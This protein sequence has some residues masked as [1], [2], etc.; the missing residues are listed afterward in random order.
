MINSVRYSLPQFFLKGYV[1]SVKLQMAVKH[2]TQH[3]KVPTILK[4]TI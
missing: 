4:Q 3:H 1:E 2:I